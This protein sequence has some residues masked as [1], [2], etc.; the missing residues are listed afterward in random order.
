MADEFKDVDVLVCARAAGAKYALAQ[1]IEIP[2]A[3]E[4]WLLATALTGRLR[5]PAEYPP[6]ET[7][8]TL[9]ETSADSLVQQSRSGFSTSAML[10]ALQSPAPPQARAFCSDAT[11]SIFGDATFFVTQRAEQEYPELIRQ[12]QSHGRTR[13]TW[14]Q[15]G[16]TAKGASQ[17]LSVHFHSEPPFSLAY[18]SCLFTSIRFISQTQN[19]V[20]CHPCITHWRPQRRER[21]PGGEKTGLPCASPSVG[22]TSSDVAR[23]QCLLSF[24]FISLAIPALTALCLAFCADREHER[25][26]A[27]ARGRL[28]LDDE[29]EFCTRWHSQCHCLAERWYVKGSS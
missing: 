21:R 13:R 9:M 3:G 23:R 7:P 28:R 24:C 25:T 5:A 12:L 4:A 20:K 29:P 11:R 6:L 22:G 15:E 17:L 14:E 16:N 27:F 10:A 2:V 8:A 18:C 26:P 19:D 1:K